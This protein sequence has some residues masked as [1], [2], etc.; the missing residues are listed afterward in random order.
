MKAREQK[1]RKLIDDLVYLRGYKT[2]FGTA[3]LTKHYETLVR[4]YCP[5]LEKLMKH[6]KCGLDGILIFAK[7]PDLYKRMDVYI[8]LEKIGSFKLSEIEKA[9]QTTS[10]NQPILPFM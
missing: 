6:K 4:A 8:E 5:T 10:S 1:M 9:F 2:T 7:E 3:E